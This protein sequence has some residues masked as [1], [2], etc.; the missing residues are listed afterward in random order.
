MDDSLDFIIED[1]DTAKRMLWG[2]CIKT[3]GL[4]NIDVYEM[5]DFYEHQMNDIYRMAT[6]LQLSFFLSRNQWNRE[7]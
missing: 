2:R 7:P 4:A 1:P 5:K 6:H 3:M